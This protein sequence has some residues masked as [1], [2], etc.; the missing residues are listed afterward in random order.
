MEPTEALRTSSKNELVTFRSI[1]I[2]QI[3]LYWP[4][5]PLLNLFHSNYRWTSL[6]PLSFTLRT[7]E[8]FSFHL[9]KVVVP[10]SDLFIDVFLPRCCLNDDFDVW[11]VCMFAGRQRRR[12]R[13]CW[14][15]RRL[16]VFLIHQRIIIELVRHRGRG[17]K[18]KFL[19][20]DE[21]SDMSHKYKSEREKLH[22]DDFFLKII[23]A[24]Q[25]SH[26]DFSSR[27][28]HREVGAGSQ[29]LRGLNCSINSRTREYKRAELLISKS[30][31][32]TAM[33]DIKSAS[34]CALR[35]R[36]TDWESERKVHNWINSLF[37]L[38]LF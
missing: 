32:C 7:C 3:F 35:E 6:P 8:C 11:N 30:C 15:W 25:K 38:S 9:S 37:T 2:S 34:K 14:S 18:I 20:C 19:W 36:E 5:R 16:V 13:N 28:L 21:N 4:S 24:T 1:L 29:S 26:S 31:I 23:R 10:S 33:M 12:P 22:C 27:E 17:G